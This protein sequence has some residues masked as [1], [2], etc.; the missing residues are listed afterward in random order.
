M[1]AA[2]KHKALIY[3]T[4]ADR[5]LAF[6]EP[7][8]PHLLPQV[9]GGTIEE[10]EMPRE[11]ALR[12]FQE[13]TG[14]PVTGDIRFLNCFD[15]H[16]PAITGTFIHRRHFFHLPVKETPP[17]AWE[18]FEMTPAGGD[19]P[20]RLAFTWIPITHAAKLLGYGHAIALPLLSQPS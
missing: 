20:I 15:F 9:P 6:T 5:L 11:A 8:D 16:D 4:F 7:D 1:Q 12:E 3:A 18:H 17:E 2:V 19:A 10:G 13:E 14:L